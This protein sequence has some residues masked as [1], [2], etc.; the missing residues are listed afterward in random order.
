MLLPLFVPIDPMLSSPLRIV[1][2]K[3]AFDK[4]SLLVILVFVFISVGAPD[5]KLSFTNVALFTSY[6]IK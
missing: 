3:A 4:A 5:E 2:K 6:I 1:R